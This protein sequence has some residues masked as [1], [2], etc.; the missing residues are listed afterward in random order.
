VGVGQQRIG[1]VG[2]VECAMRVRAARRQ[3]GADG[4]DAQLEEEPIPGAGFNTGLRMGDYLKSFAINIA[5]GTNE[6]MRNLIAE[7]ILGL[8]KG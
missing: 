3:V 1:L 5:G 8:P 7:R 6:I 4:I 2:R